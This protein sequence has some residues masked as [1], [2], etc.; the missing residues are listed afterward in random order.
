M[1]EDDALGALFKKNRRVES[2]LPAIK[3]S[4]TGDKIS[5]V[6]LGW[7]IA[8][9]P[10]LDKDKPPVENLIL[11]IE[12]DE[13][14]TQTK[15]VENKETGL[16]VDTEITGT[17]W[18]WFLKSGSQVLKALEDAM[19]DNRV[20]GAPVKGDRGRAKLIGLKPTKYPKP[21]Q[22]FEFQYKAAAVRSVGDSPLPA[23]PPVQ[24]PAVLHLDDS[25]RF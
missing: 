22:I 1:A 18:L 10:N 14:R 7:S 17:H 15:Q 9:I 13:P 6:F 23:G 5:F 8:S 2:N 12:L 21:Q 19:G 24:A 4:A 11:E 20:P 3:F 16:M 25:D